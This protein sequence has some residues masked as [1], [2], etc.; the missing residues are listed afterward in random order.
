MSPAVIIALSVAVLVFLAAVV[1]LTA[2]RK[3]DVRGAGA[4]SRET[5]RRD[6]DADIDLPVAPSGKAVERAAVERDGHGFERTGGV[7]G[8]E[9]RD[10]HSGENQ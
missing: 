6:R 1:L 2:A 3:S 4:L 8:G 10:Q 7:R 5:R 9:C